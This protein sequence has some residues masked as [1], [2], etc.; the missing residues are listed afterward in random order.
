MAR[1]RH[2]ESFSFNT[3]AVLS[4]L[5]AMVFVASLTQTAWART[6]LS[7]TA[8]KLALG[9]LSSAGMDAWQAMHAHPCA[10][11]LFDAVPQVAKALWPVL[12][13]L[14]AAL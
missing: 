9:T 13:H 5:T 4:G 14:V 1:Q 3:G 10:E 11:W 12:L 2:S 6:D 8:M 7:C